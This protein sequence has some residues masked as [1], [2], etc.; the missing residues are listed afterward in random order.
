M[1][2]HS[3]NNI[4]KKIGSEFPPWMKSNN[5]PMRDISYRYRGSPLSETY[6]P[7]GPLQ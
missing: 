4:G 7:I 2:T 1:D 3:P 5:P 6:G